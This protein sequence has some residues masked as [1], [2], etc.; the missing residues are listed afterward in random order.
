MSSYKDQQKIKPKIEEIAE[1]FL[2]GDN[3]NHFMDLL[4][5]LKDNKLNPRWDYINRW[6]FNYKNKKVCYIRIND[7]GTWIFYPNQFGSKHFSDWFMEYNQYIT[8]DEVKAFVWANLQ[9]DKRCA[10]ECKGIENI[11]ILGKEFKRICFCWT[12][13]VTNPERV[14][15]E[16]AKKLVVTIKNIIADLAAASKS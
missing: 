14:D 16:C 12:I 10:R 7:D 6:S 4:G 2:D 1:S 15:L 13:G 8:D 3:L 9:Q 5:F 11:V